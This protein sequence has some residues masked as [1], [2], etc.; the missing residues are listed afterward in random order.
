MPL[1]FPPKPESTHLRGFHASNYEKKENFALLNHN[2]FNDAQ[3]C[4]K[5]CAHPVLS[6][7]EVT[8]ITVQAFWL[9]LL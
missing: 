2:H 7:T 1:H 6:V 3:C 8:R 4:G 9:G 5:N